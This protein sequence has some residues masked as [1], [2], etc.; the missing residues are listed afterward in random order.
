MTYLITFSDIF[1]GH[2]QCWTFG[3]PKVYPDFRAGPFRAYTLFGSAYAIGSPV[4][5]KGPRFERHLMADY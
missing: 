4:H 3:V 5:P 1:L 2:S